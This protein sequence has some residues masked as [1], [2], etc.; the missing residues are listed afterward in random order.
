MNEKE[1]F[2]LVKSGTMTYSQFRD[3]LEQIK[4]NEWD[5]GY[6]ADFVKVKM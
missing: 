4:I 6:R 1:V 3:W 2:E 5:E